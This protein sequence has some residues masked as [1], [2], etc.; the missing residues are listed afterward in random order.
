MNAPITNYF[1]KAIDFYNASD[2][3]A[4]IELLDRAF[5]LSLGDLAEILVYRGSS[6]AYLGDYENAMEDF[7]AAIRRNPYLAEAY[8]ERGSL[9]R[10]QEQ[11]ERAIIDY[12]MALRIDPDHYEA[13][14]NRA[15]SHVALKQHEE[16]EADLTRA[17]ELNPG[18]APAYEIRGRVRAEQLNYDG[19]IDDLRRYLR[20]G[21][22]REFDNHSEIQSY[23]INL[24]INKFLSYFLPARF[25][26]GNRA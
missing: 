13:C 10:L 14:Y 26:P 23:L 24:R 18:I 2:Y 21:G 9:L 16:A 11:H 7:N 5:R 25:L 6:Y 22:G 19:A 20:M 8:N 4:A 17:L 3:E 1:E 12:T 15:L